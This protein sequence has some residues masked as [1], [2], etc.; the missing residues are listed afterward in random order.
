MIIDGDGVSRCLELVDVGVVQ[1]A[2]YSG[3]EVCG[4]TP[5]ASH[6]ASDNFG[7]QLGRWPNTA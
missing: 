7:L 4:R 1:L 3:A 5:K 2:P 6:T